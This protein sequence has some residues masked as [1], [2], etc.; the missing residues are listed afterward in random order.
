M[1]RRLVRTGV[2]FLGGCAIALAGR[3]AAAQSDTSRSFFSFNGGYQTPSR[4]FADTATFRLHAE[5][6]AAESRYEVTPG[7][8][9]DVHGGVR[10]WRG[11][12]LG[13]GVTRYNRSGAASVSGQLPHPFF[14]G[15]PRTATG[16][17][18]DLTH[19]QVAIHIQALW[20][21][22][23]G[24]AF[25]LA[26]FG[27][28]SVFRVTQGLVSS[29]EGSESYPFDTATLRSIQTERQ[30]DTRIGFHAGVDVAYFLSS[31]IGTGVLVRFSRANV[32]VPT[33][34]ADGLSIDAGGAEVAAGVRLRF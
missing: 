32:D 1:N 20:L 27:G 33:S 22:G 10:V 5:D 11:L 21:T 8:T 3:P 12:A 13:M 14:F 34:D 4:E 16:S 15:R 30:R 29:L 2:V 6:A 31:H 28:P 26:V 9:F 19:Q 24:R 23:V 17:A 7:P 18:A 25:T